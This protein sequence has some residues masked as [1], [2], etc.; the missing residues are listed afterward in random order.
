MEIK[1]FIAALTD[2]EVGISNLCNQLIASANKRGKDYTFMPHALT[3]QEASAIARQG[4]TVTVA[5]DGVYPDKTTM[6]WSN[7]DKKLIYVDKGES[8]IAKFCGNDT[9]TVEYRYTNNHRNCTDSYTVKCHYSNNGEDCKK[10]Y[11]VERQQTDND[12]ECSE[13]YVIDINAA[14]A[15]V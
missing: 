3:V 12:Q 14:V 1:K 7:S 8:F 4:R 5:A 15:A 11:I 2:D 13:R 9:T 10:R 6:E